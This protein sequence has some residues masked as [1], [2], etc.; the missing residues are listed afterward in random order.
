[1]WIK[2]VLKEF[3]SFV[4]LAQVPVLDINALFIRADLQ[5]CS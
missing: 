4:Y 5:I 2:T 1:M 3:A